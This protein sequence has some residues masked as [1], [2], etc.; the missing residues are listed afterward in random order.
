MGSFANLVRQ[1]SPQ[2]FEPL[3]LLDRAAIVAFRLGLIAQKQGPNVGLAGHLLETFAQQ[4]VAILGARD[5]DI[6]TPASSGFMRVIGVPRQ[7]Q[8]V[9][10][11]VVKRPASSR[12]ARRSACWASAMRSRAKSSWE[13]TGW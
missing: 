2:G 5:F 7:S 3:E 8:A 12:A 10:R 6:A 4:V 9:L 13:L 1:F 11:A